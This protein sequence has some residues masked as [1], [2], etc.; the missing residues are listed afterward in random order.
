MLV[1]AGDLIKAFVK[2]WGHYPNL[3]NLEAHS[4][5]SKYL[6][7]A[8]IPPMLHI[9]H[10]RGV[11]ELTEEQARRVEMLLGPH[12]HTVIKAYEALN[13]SMEGKIPE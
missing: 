5:F 2:W 3:S 1:K 8:L 10:W 12:A 9:T 4:S 13:S 6:D 11:W 7:A